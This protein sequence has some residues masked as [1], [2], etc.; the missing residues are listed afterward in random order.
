MRQQIIN[1]Q[2][3]LKREVHI[4]GIGLHSGLST[5]VTIQ[6]ALPNTGIIFVRGD[7]P[8]SPKITA[9]FDHV[10]E[11][12]LATV[13]GIGPVKVSTVEHLLAALR[14]MGIDNACVVVQG[15]EIPILDGSAAPFIR[16]L[17]TAGIY[18]Q[19]VER[20]W[21]R[22]KKTV[23]VKGDGKWARIEPADK[24]SVEATVSWEHPSIGTQSHFYILGQSRPEEIASAR[25]FGFLKEVE[26]LRAKGLAR[27]GSLDNAVVLDEHSV[28]NAEGLR[29]TDEF[30]RHKVLDAIGDFALAPIPF[31]GRVTLYK[32]GHE[33]HAAL[34]K[35]IFSDRSNIEWVESAE[36]VR[37]A[38]GWD[39]WL[40]N[41]AWVQPATFSLNK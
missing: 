5:S 36:P 4:H 23:E 7:L 15:A 11:T 34:V 8:D 31:I 41:E 12:R 6:P 3:T 21:V 37:A 9:S 17:E 25:T 2:R 16:A 24:L 1:Q 33:L 13:L 38:S 30:V 32:A 26:M 10:V 22:L 19:K 39:S 14:L 29:F 27:G 18:E 20:K 28:L 35:A 40:S